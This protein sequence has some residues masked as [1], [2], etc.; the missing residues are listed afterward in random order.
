MKAKRSTLRIRAVLAVSIFLVVTSVVLGE[1]LTQQS[2]QAMKMLVDE[3]EL[4]IV[5]T[6]ADML[7]GDALRGITD[8]DKG[9]PAYD[10]TFNIMSSF[11]KNI[12]LEYIYVVREVE[13][14]SY[15]FVI[16]PSAENAS[17]YGDLAHVTEALKTAGRGTPA[18]D[19]VPYTDSFGH[20][21]S[22]YS[23]VFD[24]SGDVTGIVAADFDAEWI[25]SQ[26][27]KNTLTVVVACIVF[28]AA[29]IG[30]TMLLTRQY[31]A[32]FEM[33]NESLGDL[34][35]DIDSL[36][37]ELTGGAIDSVAAN[38]GE[39]GMQALGAHIDI[40]RDNLREYVS[41]VDTQ[42]N[43]MITAMASDYR[44]VYHVNLDDNDGVC[45]RG[46][47]DVTVQTGEGVHFP[48]LERFTW[49]ANNV[50]AE[51][52]REGFLRFIQPDAIREAL[53]THS[54]IAYRYLARWN[55]QEYYEMIRMAGVRR[56][57]DRDDGMVHA[58]GLG[59]TVIDAEMRETLAKN[60]ALAEAL[61]MADEAN[62]AKTAFLNNMSH[63]IRTPMNAI[64]GL[65][66][67]ALQD[68]TLS[69]QTRE[70]L[71]K[72][73]VSAAH[74][75]D[76][77]NG[78]LDMSRIESGKVVLRQEEFSLYFMLEQ[79]NAMV[80]S[81]CG[82]KGLTYECR[83][84]NA[85]DDR[86]VGDDMR[87]EEIL[88]NILSNAIK[89]TDAPGSV[90]LSV[91]RMAKFEGQST[92]RFAVEDT[93]IGIDEDYIPK[94]FDAFSQEDSTRKNKYGSTGLG[95]AITKNIVE[96]MN[97][98]IQVESQ[99]GVGS[100]FTVIVTLS[101]AA[102][103]ALSHEETAA[104]GGLGSQ[105][106]DNVT[107]S[108]Y[109]V[110]NPNGEEASGQANLAG[111]HLLLAEDIE[112][113]AEIM[114]EILDMEGIACDHAANGK[115]AVEMFESS[116]VFAYDAILMDIRMPVMD[117][118]EA[119]SAIRAL[120]RE[121]ARRVPIIALTANAFDE[122]VQISLQSGMNAHL[123]KPVD[124][125]RLLQ[126]L[127]DLINEAERVTGSVTGDG[128]VDTLSCGCAI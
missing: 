49:Y 88:I 112:V 114:I 9:T 56:A 8:A 82:E 54:I 65:N 111:Y 3:H 99:K 34:T 61:A 7:N 42:A 62:M 74:L 89:F 20:F 31:N 46:D 102:P 108:E 126:T 48:Y 75:L 28:V 107:G 128:G 83:I 11:E 68:T 94:I 60:E 119:A 96:M 41:H 29:G 113:N 87:L 17:A 47:P 125:D 109:L 24:S 6:A 1:M 86:Y 16:D 21:Y 36:T 32:R 33:I 67:L 43:S 71:E 90:T 57:E 40:L 58:I 115:V 69:D 63:E 15:I 45:Y 103:D 110:S 92:L 26:V 118:L 95:M 73:G 97:G 124:F 12:G 77:I 100:K 51:T 104:L 85:V 106:N 35:E 5:N 50:V 101:N 52:Y 38:E 70:Y 22:A 64:I 116:E 79:I 39:N 120:N 27:D 4:D 123:A 37:S 72:I 122:D 127:G 19:D 53:A 18:V 105:D 91:D 98:E 55:G 44:S 23:P 117:G 93:G 13:D 10:E 66:T 80:M 2:R 25:D 30:I 59:L 76:L 121:D 84:L 78:I 81:Q 14:G